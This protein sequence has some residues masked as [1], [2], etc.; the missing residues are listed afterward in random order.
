MKIYRFEHIE[1]GEGPFCCK[2]FL[3][4]D[5]NPFIKHNGPHSFDEYHDFTKSKGN[6]WT[7]LS[8]SPY[9]FGM[10]SLSTLLGLLRVQEQVMYDKGF[11]I[12]VY[13]AEEDLVTFP[14][15]QVMFNKEKARRVED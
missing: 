4:S 13:D 9:F 14:D 11:V 10:K 5:F 15:G 7:G 2:K 3:K 1:D 12:A 8:G 6:K